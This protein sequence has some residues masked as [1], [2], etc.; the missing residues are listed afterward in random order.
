[1]K[2]KGMALVEIIIALAIFAIVV[3]VIFFFYMSHYKAL[4]KTTIMS[5]LQLQG[6]KAR[7]QLSNIFMEGSHIDKV[8]DKEGNEISLMN[9]L[10]GVSRIV[11]IDGEN[12]RHDIYIENNEIK[13]LKN[14]KYEGKIAGKVDSMKVKNAGIKKDNVKG[15]GIMK[16]YIKFKEKDLEYEVD[17]NVNLRNR[18]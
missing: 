7:E 4:D 11:F 5:D 6:G 16:F 18:E 17:F 9:E 1:M 2:K 8:T 10:V 3:P 14:N 12:M 15:V 13:H